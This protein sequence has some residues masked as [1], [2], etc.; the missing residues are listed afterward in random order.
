MADPEG[1][2]IGTIGEEATIMHQPQPPQKFIQRLNFGV[3]K[4]A[5]GMSTHN[6]VVAANKRGETL[7]SSVAGIQVVWFV[8]AKQKA[9]CVC[10]IKVHI[11]KSSS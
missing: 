4:K 7:I 9:R 5:K 11:I 8:V 10:L 2:K 1:D 6:L 3:I